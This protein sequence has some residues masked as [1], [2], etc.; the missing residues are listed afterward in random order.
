MI[1]DNKVDIPNEDLQ[2]F[3]ER[4]KE[5]SYKN[6]SALLTLGKQRLQF[7]LRHLIKLSLSKPPINKDCS[8]FAEIYK[9]SY[10]LTF[11][12]ENCKEFDTF[13]MKF[14]NV[15]IKIGNYTSDIDSTK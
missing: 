10:S 3:K 8:K 2:D 6:C 11:T 4:S 5:S 15:L 1:L 13:I 12:L 14:N 7:V 9:N